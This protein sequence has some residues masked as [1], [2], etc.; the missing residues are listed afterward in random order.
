MSAT[1]ATLIPILT[2]LSTTG[3]GILA[4]WLFGRLRAHIPLPSAAPAPLLARL[5]LML[6]Y[7]PRWSRCTVLVLAG[8]LGMVFS[9]LLALLQGQPVAPIVDVL[10]A[11]LIS[12]IWHA[13]TSLS[14]TLPQ[15]RR[16]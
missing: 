15:E 9:V 6:L 11:A 5:G 2:F 4:S 3:A 14:G 1:T 12:Q 13:A 7:A 8:L 16:L 10:L